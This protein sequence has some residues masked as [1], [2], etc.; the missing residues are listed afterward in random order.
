M[1]IQAMA[2][3]SIIVLLGTFA[4]LLRYA[5][6]WLKVS[7]PRAVALFVFAFLELAGAAVFGVDLVENW[8]RLGHESAVMGFL[9][10]LGLMFK[11]V[12]PLFPASLA[13]LVI[14][15]LLLLGPAGARARP[16]GR[17]GQ[18]PEA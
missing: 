8:T 1:F 17:H 3:A 11:N 13:L 18:P 10:L 16:D 2:V 9:I 14:S 6:S 5:R 4:V 15:L 7:R 12:V